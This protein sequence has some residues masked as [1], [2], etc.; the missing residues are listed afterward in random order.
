MFFLVLRPIIEPALHGQL[1]MIQELDVRAFIDIVH[2]TGSMVTNIKAGWPTRL[3]R[4]RVTPIQAVDDDSSFTYGRERDAG[5]EIIVATMQ[6]QVLGRGF[7][8]G[9]REQSIQP[10][11]LSL[12]L[13]GPLANV[14]NLVGLFD[15]QQI[16]KC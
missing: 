2:V 14:I 5:M 10:D 6:T 1:D 16:F 4:Q 13:L 11:S 3:D 12:V 7:N 15:R 8:T 9:R